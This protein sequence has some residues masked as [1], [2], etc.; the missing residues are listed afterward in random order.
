MNFIGSTLDKYG[1]KHI[2]LD[3]KDLE[4]FSTELFKKCDVATIKYSDS[5]L[6]PCVLKILKA[7]DL[8]K[9]KPGNEYLEQVCV[10]GN[11]SGGY[12]I[13]EKITEIKK[14]EAYRESNYE[15]VSFLSPQILIKLSFIED[16]D[17]NLKNL[18]LNEFKVIQKCIKSNM[19]DDSREGYKI[20]NEIILKIVDYIHVNWLIFSEYYNE[21]ILFECPVFENKENH[22]ID[23]NKQVDR[24]QK[25]YLIDENNDIIFLDKYIVLIKKINNKNSVIT[26][27]EHLYN[28]LDYLFKKF[29]YQTGRNQEFWEVNYENLPKDSRINAVHN[30]VDILLIWSTGMDLDNNEKIIMNN[31][32]DNIKSNTDDLFLQLKKIETELHF[33]PKSGQF[34]FIFLFQL[35][36][37]YIK[38]I[39]LSNFYDVKLIDKF[40]KCL[41]I[42]NK[43]NELVIKTL[44]SDQGEKIINFFEKVDRNHLEIYCLMYFQDKILE[45]YPKK[46][47]KILNESLLE[48]WKILTG[49]ENLL[50]QHK[51]HINMI[52]PVIDTS[53]LAYGTKILS[54]N[55]YFYASFLI[56]EAEMLIK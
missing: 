39:Q 12:V 36:I 8:D 46:N 4:K 54:F 45:K 43:K 48:I 38:H 34:F 10:Y 37:F 51:K 23:E 55:Q 9:Y 28:K 26:L 15:Q 3:D 41:V 20:Y 49:K 44:I 18:G 24:N 22:T 2:F 29:F 35:I 32:L 42:N 16:H 47:K 33:H 19:N 52:R 17:F 40:N 14:K 27:S 56:D 5:S 6:D 13:F 1:I 21:D 53:F 25:N 50:R 7:H 11:E 31:F 30:T